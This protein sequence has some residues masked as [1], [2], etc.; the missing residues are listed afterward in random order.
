MEKPA[1]REEE[2]GGILGRTVGAILGVGP[3]DEST[4]DQINLNE[5]KFEELR[6]LGM[7]VTQATR[8]ITYRERHNG[9][10]SLDELAAVP[11]LPRELLNDVNPR[12]T[13]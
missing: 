2:G 4:A 9:F 6:E 1:D 13:L 5:A 10:D 8:V 3:G 7:S 12:L 11:G